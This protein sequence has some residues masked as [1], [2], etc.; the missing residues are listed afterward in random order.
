MVTQIAGTTSVATYIG[1]DKNTERHINLFKYNA[2]QFK[3]M[4]SLNHKTGK[5]EF[6]VGMYILEAGNIRKINSIKWSPALK[7]YTFGIDDCPLLT[8]ELELTIKANLNDAELTPFK[9]ILSNQFYNTT[10][11]FR[12]ERKKAIENFRYCSTLIKDITN[13]KP[14]INEGKLI[15]SA[16]ALMMIHAY[17]GVNPNTFF[18][19]NNFTINNLDWTGIHKY[20]LQ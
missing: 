9:I 12:I 19:N 5:T 8:H 15:V 13:T 3:Q 4:A 1:F 18:A 10:D 11:L 14:R 7:I 16:K 17:T 20:K 2:E 6:V